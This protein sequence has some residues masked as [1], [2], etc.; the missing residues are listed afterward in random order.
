MGGKC[1]SHALVEANGAGVF[2][3]DDGIAHLVAL[4]AED[5]FGGQV[6]LPADAFSPGFGDQIDG[7][8]SAPAV[9]CP[10]IGG[11]AVDI[12]ENRAFF[13][14]NQPGELGGDVPESGKEFLLGGHGVFKCVGGG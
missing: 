5:F 13:F 12:A 8:F 10:G 2:R 11:A 14:P 4:A 7:K 1:I 3:G 6:E 9:G